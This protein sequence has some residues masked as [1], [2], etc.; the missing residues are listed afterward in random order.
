VESLNLLFDFMSSEC[1]FMRMI[2]AGTTQSPNTSKIIQVSSCVDKNS[3][4]NLNATSG[5]K[6]FL[7]YFMNT[8]V[9]IFLIYA[10][11]SNTAI[12]RIA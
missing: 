2:L 5:S 10:M 1:D 4:S 3:H 6:M 12:A 7:K 11:D 9:F 8:N